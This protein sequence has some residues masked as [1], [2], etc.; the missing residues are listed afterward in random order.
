MASSPGHRSFVFRSTPAVAASRTRVRYV[1]CAVCQTDKASYLFTKVGVR[2]VQCN[3]CG[4]VYVNPVG[5]AGESYFDMTRL[6]HFDEADQRLFLRDFE[7][8]LSRV[9]ADFSSVEHRPPKRSALLGRYLD[10]MAEV[11]TAQRM[12][13]NVLAID[14][15]QF[16]ALVES[17]DVSWAKE[18]VSSADIVILNEF[19][20]ASSNPAQ[21]IE[22]LTKMA[23]KGAWF[24]VTYANTDSLPAAL[25]R[26]YW[27]PFFDYKRAYFNTQNMTA[28]LARFGYVIHAQSAVPITQTA[29][30]VAKRLSPEGA[31]SSVVGALP[32]ANVPVPLR[33]GVRMAVFRKQPE[34]APKEKLSIVLPVF[35]EA[36]YA[37]QVI[38][39]VLSK[40]L[41]IEKEV[42]IV[43]SNST[44]GTRDIVKK[45]E[46]HPEVRLIFEDKPQGKG[47][48]VRTGLKA[49]SGTIIL[50]Q[51]ADFEYDIDDYDALLE[52]ILQH[53]TMFVLG[54]RSLGLDDWKVR[55]FAKNRAKG[56]VL[57]AAQVLFAKTFN[58][59]YQQHVTDV[60]TMFKVFRAECL[61]GLDLHSNGFE[62]DIEL[63]CKL[64][65]N[66]NAALEVPVNYV[67]RG[68]EE[69]KKI[70]FVRDSFP[71]YFAFF[72]YRFGE[73]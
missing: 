6:G 19:L 20:E 26:R 11:P 31:L 18:A 5:D 33:T 28:L 64:V 23:P 53:K 10:G 1:D 16:R 40:K 59:L 14:D 52:P 32:V 68:F 57:N 22:Q 63:A 49:V 44:D 12:G 51:D 9:E 48:A 43:E 36:R 60:N 7:K 46:G 41:K 38:D 30:Y 34:D 37:A 50:I 8:M 67:A 72:K 69:G 45:Y 24:V 65:K 55:K 21:A 27:V 73:K 42:I 15:E 25:L 70:S 71:S 17:A 4:L 29:A 35:N 61:E 62:L 13:L 54:S 66:G 3:S 39:A 2:F 47:H 56:F 58:V